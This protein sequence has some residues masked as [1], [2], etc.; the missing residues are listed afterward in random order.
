M[1]QPHFTPRKDPVPILQEAGWAPGPVWTA[2]DLVPTGIQSQTIRPL[3]SR[4]TDWA[5]WPTF[6]ACA[7]GKSVEKCVVSCCG[8]IKLPQGSSISVVT[9]L[10]T[11]RLRVCGSIPGRGKSCISSAKFPDQFL[12][13][14][15]PPAQQVQGALAPA[16][17][18]PGLEV[19][20]TLPSSAKVMNEWNYISTPTVCLHGEHRDSCCFMH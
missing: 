10:L 3:V 17:E 6:A 9:R 7:G 5:T 15:Q 4:Y 11:L 19:D 18:W 2:E 12:G 16:I 20:Q 1:P 8:V 13:P 14:T